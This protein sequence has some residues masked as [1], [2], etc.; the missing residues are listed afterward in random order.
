MATAS[1]PKISSTAWQK[2]RARAATAPT[3]PI[4]PSSIAALLGMSSPRSAID[5]VVLPLRR[6]GLVDDDGRLTERGKKW[7]VDDSY[8]EACQE[9]LDEIYPSDLTSLTDDQ[10]RP[11]KS[12]VNSWFQ[13]HGFGDA[14][15]TKMA[16][17]YNLIAEK[18]IPESN[19]VE[20]KKKASKAAPKARIK[21]D[22]APVVAEADEEPSVETLELPLVN[23]RST[24]SGPNIHLD[25]QIHI[26]AT[27][28]PDQIEQIF[29]SMAKH[30]YQ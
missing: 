28:T 9:I 2:V 17:T 23:E 14:N 21:K 15:A 29:A 27:A 3:A 11:E 10:G 6:L 8:G 13:Y 22:A 24:K 25:I 1:Y 18:R 20:P 4:T 16:A 5:N 12:Q 19:S 30:L 26:P 7:R